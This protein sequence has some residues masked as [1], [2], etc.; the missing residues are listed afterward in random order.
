MLVQQ[1][2]PADVAGVAFS[3]NPINNNRDEVVINMSWGLGESIVGGTVTPDTYVV[4]KGELSVKE[5]QIAEKEKMA[6]AHP[7]GTLYRQYYGVE[8]LAPALWHRQRYRWIW[9]GVGASAG[10]GV[11]GGAGQFGH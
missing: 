8:S 2:V 1:M 5:R 11:F 10:C 3:A 9:P 7:E 4:D 6:V